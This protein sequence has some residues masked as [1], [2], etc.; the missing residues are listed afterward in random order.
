MLCAPLKGINVYCRDR[1]NRTT[2]VTHFNAT[3]RTTEI[4]LFVS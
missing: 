4:R 2:L 3:S 1:A